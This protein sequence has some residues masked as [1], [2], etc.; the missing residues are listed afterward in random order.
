MFISLFLYICIFAFADLSAEEQEALDNSDSD[1][2]AETSSDDESDSSKETSSDD[3][4]EVNVL[5]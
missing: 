4:Y 5:M 2:S 1:S 3:D